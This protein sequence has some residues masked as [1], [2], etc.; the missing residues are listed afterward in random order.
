MLD[1]GQNGSY[2][3]RSSLS[4]PGDYV[5]S[6]LIDNRVS[7]VMIRCKDNKYDVGGG[8]Q[9]NGLNELIDH[10][11]KIPLVEITG[12]YPWSLYTRTSVNLITVNLLF[13]TWRILN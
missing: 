3:V 2:L 13:Q 9:F 1:R 6:A 4:Q 12:E 5:L 10:Y 11:K 8:Q 7:H